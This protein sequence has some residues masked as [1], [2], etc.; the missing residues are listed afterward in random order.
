MS[1]IFFIFLSVFLV[2]TGIIAVLKGLTS[3]KRENESTSDFEF[4][5]FKVSGPM[6]FVYGILALASVSAIVIKWDTVTGNQQSFEKFETQ[7]VH[8]SDSRFITVKFDS[9]EAIS[10][11]KGEVTL[12]QSSY[13]TLVFNGVV[14]VFK[15]LDDEAIEENRISV[16]EGDK[17]FI[18][19]K[20][21]SIWGVNVLHKREYYHLEFYEYQ[22]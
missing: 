1:E 18:V 8:S 13:G 5:G 10:V 22:S 7:I 11:F 16:D 2:A 19:R 21:A 15:E 6:S 3:T 20:D 4:K 12:K 17:F 14:G 9:R